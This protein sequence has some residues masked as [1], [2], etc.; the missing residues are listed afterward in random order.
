LLAVVKADRENS[1]ASF[2]LGI[3]YLL[4][5]RDSDGIARL[6]DT[7]TLGDSPELEE[8]HFYLAKALLRQHDRSGARAELERAIALKGPRLAEE[9]SLLRNLEEVAP[10]R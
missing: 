7:I 10:S 6:R 8:A 9:E 3:C 5:G 1:A 2:F 4:E